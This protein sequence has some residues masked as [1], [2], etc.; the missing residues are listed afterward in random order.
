MRLTFTKNVTGCLG[1]NDETLLALLM[2]ISFIISV[3]NMS[4]AEV[5]Y[6]VN[7][8]GEFTVTLSDAKM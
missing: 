7:H 6:K 2:E 8:L 3:R 4:S 5:F 1:L